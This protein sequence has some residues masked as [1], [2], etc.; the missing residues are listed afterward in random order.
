MWE[1]FPGPKQWRCSLIVAVLESY[2][3][4]RKQC[5]W[6]AQCLPDDWEVILLDDGSQ[7][8]LDVPNVVPRHFSLVLTRDTRP[9]TQPLARNLGAR[10]ARA[11]LL[12]LTDIDH[13]LSREAIA[14]V[15]MI[16]F[17][18]RTGECETGHGSLDLRRGQ[19][20]QKWTARAD[21]AAASA[22]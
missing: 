4:V 6:W 11:D 15:S 7:P 13:M 5:L 1:R 21:Q 22:R 9:W 17:R 3:I 20:T 8:P 18:E 14:A 19:D 16:R 2:E 12:F 10:L